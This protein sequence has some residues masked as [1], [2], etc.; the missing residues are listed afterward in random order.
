VE[1]FS[2]KHY[3]HIFLRTHILLK[4]FPDDIVIL[5]LLFASHFPQNDI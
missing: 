1:A 2:Q 4:S 5:K 3:R